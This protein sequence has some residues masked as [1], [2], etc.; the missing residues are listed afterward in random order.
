MKKTKVISYK[1]LPAKSPIQVTAVI[2]LVLDRM[3]AQQ[4]AWGAMGVLVI[5]IWVSYI[6]GRITEEEIEINVVAKPWAP[7]E[8]RFKGFGE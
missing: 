2:W 4:W 1:S 7:P 6:Y 8:A 3:R 5:L